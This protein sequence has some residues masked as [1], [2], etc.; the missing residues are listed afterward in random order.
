MHGGIRPLLASD[1]TDSA[2]ENKYGTNTKSSVLAIKYV[3]I[4]VVKHSN[5][6][7]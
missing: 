2:N 5:L 6:G 7:F 3:H 1:F 4:A